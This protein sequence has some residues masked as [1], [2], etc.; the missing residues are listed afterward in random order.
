MMWRWVF[1]KSIGLINCW[2]SNWPDRERQH[3]RG[4]GRG[5]TYFTKVCFNRQSKDVEELFVVEWNVADTKISVSIHV[6]GTT[7]RVCV[8]RKK[9][10]LNIWN[11]ANGIYKVLIYSIHGL[12]NAL[13]EWMLLTWRFQSMNKSKWNQLKR[14][15]TK[16]GIWIGEILFSDYKINKGTL[17]WVIWSESEIVCRR[18]VYLRRTIC[19]QFEEDSSTET[20]QVD[21]DWRRSVGTD[22]NLL[23]V[24]F[25]D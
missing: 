4:D 24:C 13:K 16:Q 21:G 22:M 25:I 9:Q 10:T 14:W 5:S 7:E 1:N 2:K 12:I 19:C 6:E 11:W 8:K 15:K 17:P 20:G 23:Q 3:W 18:D